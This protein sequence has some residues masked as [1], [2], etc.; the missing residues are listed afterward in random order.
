MAHLAGIDGRLWLGYTENATIMN[1]EG[2]SPFVGRKVFQIT[3]DVKRFID[4]YSSVKVYVDGDEVTSGFTLY[5]AGGLVVF[6]EA[7]DAGDDV[8]I[9][10]KYIPMTA[11]ASAKSISYEL[12]Q[13]TEDVTTFG[14][15]ACGSRWGSNAASMRQGSGSIEV[16]FDAEGPDEWHDA[17]FGDESE[18]P[19]WVGGRVIGIQFGDCGENWTMYM[20]AFLTGLT[21]QSSATGIATETLNFIIGNDPP[22][23]LA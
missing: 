9:S 15:G 21:Q 16:L 12:T 19:D 3:N 6:D 22:Y 14:T 13:S 2:T 11:I 10:G 4:P 17:M 18:N 20:L 23:L 8:T 5:R 7:V 1:A